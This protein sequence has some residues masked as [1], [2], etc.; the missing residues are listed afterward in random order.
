MV[1]SRKY[2]LVVQCVFCLAAGFI[3]VSILLF[4]RRL[5]S[6]VVSNIFRW[7]TWLAIGFIAAYTIALTIAPLLGCE[8]LSAFWDQVD[9]TKLFQ[10]YTYKCFDEGA[11]IFA[12]SIISTFQDFITAV[13][14]TFLFWNLRIP[15]RQKIALF[16][17]FAIG[18]GVVALGVLRAYY[19]WQTYYNTYDVTWVSWKLFL[20][21][22]L[23][24][25][26][27]CFC[28]NAPTFKVFF[29]HFLGDRISSS[30][31]KSRSSP[32]NSSNKS[33]TSST[34]MV[35]VLFSKSNS[36]STSD[37]TSFDKKGYISDMNPGVSVDMHGGVVVQKSFH[38]GRESGL[39]IRPG[40]HSTMRQSTDTADLFLGR[41]Y[42]DIELGHMSTSHNSLISSVYPSRI[43]EDDEEVEAVPKIPASPRAMEA[44]KSFRFHP[45]S[46]AK[47]VFPQPPNPAFTRGARNPEGIRRNSCPNP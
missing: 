24:L 2:V 9:S 22:L 10:G 28:A 29:N 23:E 46:P 1:A 45:L 34:D 19:S 42:D 31:K 36:R 17:I 8:T 33:S 38:V 5:S 21:S 3:K 37:S 20:V 39:P 40:S 4:Y 30:I 12:A 47:A 15:V 25:H 18:Y 16:G 7:T 26:V 44:S 32:K 35:A 41:Y 13:L 14:P 11:D 6:R 27:G 43:A